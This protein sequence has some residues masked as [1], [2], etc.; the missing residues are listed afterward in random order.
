M[1]RFCRWFGIPL[2]ALCAGCSIAPKSFRGIL[3]PSPI[4]RARSVGLG[5]NLPDWKRIPTLIDG[6]GDSEPVVAMA[7]NEELKTL[8]GQDFGYVAWGDLAERSA[9]QA[10]WR[11]WWD[12]RQAGLAKNRTIH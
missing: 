4:V 1:P 2:M 9:A 8:T 3:H 5:E 11:A 6:L 12:A 7:A 10:R